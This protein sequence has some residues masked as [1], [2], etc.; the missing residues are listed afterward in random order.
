[1]KD[2]LERP[3]SKG[4]KFTNK[5]I[6]ADDKIQ[7]LPSM[8]FEG[9]RDRWNGWKSD[10]YNEVVDRYDQID[11][12]RREMKKKEQV[13]MGGGARR[14]VRAWRLARMQLEVCG[15]VQRCQPLQA[16]EWLA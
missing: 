1:M 12:L 2:C 4:A 15:G 7:D 11:A 6:A 5:N 8:G 16:A 14:V 13:R 3:R 9:K 10:D